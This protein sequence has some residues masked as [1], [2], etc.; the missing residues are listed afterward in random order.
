MDVH[1]RPTNPPQNAAATWNI[2]TGWE[3]RGHP[4][5][6][7]GDAPSL[8]LKGLSLRRKWLSFWLR[9]YFASSQSTGERESSSSFPQSPLPLHSPLDEKCHHLLNVPGEFRGSLQTPASLLPRP[10]PTDD[11]PPLNPL[12]VADSQT[13]AASVLGF[14]TASPGS[15]RDLLMS[16]R[17]PVRVLFLQCP[18][19]P[20]SNPTKRQPKHGRLITILRQS[21]FLTGRAPSDGTPRFIS[22][23]LLPP[24]SLLN[25]R[26]KPP[27]RPG[28]RPAGGA[29]RRAESVRPCS[30]SSA[31]TLGSRV[32]QVS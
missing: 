30:A 11:K 29:G 19:C 23:S 3:V 14:S 26:P 25:R 4:R 8:L 1:G 21:E 12:R 20:P 15:G 7:V 10:S 28:T 32:P 9:S 13:Y 18:L 5:W 22:S 31:N 16:P 27:P 6:R 2:S 24:S 17:L